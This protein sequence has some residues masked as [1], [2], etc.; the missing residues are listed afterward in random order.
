MKNIFIVFY[1][2][3]F[4]ISCEKTVVENFFFNCDEKFENCTEL[5]NDP[6]PD[7]INKESDAVAEVDDVIVNE[8]DSVAPDSDGVI[9]EEE[10]NDIVE[11]DSDLISD[12]DS[13]EVYPDVD[14][15][16]DT[17][18]PIHDAKNE[19]AAGGYSDGKNP[20]DATEV[21]KIFLTSQTDGCSVLFT[22]PSTLDAI[23][24]I[25]NFSVTITK[26]PAEMVDVTFEGFPSYFF[27]DF[28]SSNMLS[29]SI[30]KAENYDT[31]YDRTFITLPK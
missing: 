8:D 15:I 29:I 19:S 26:L 17:C 11:T 10:E 13:D 6:R 1:A 31:L 4:A 3:F 28:N 23:S 12:P 21:L 18:N 25:N 22:S 30:Y 16:V 9:T 2:V 20:E 7:S 27:M 5:D 24:K 14:I